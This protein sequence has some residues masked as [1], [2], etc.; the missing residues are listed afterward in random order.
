MRDLKE[1]NHALQREVTV[2]RDSIAKTHEVTNDLK[3]DVDL[4][5]SE[6]SKLMSTLRK[7]EKERDGLHV[8]KQELQGKFSV[9]E[10][11]LLQV[12]TLAVCPGAHGCIDLIFDYSTY[13]AVRCCN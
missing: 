7:T 13:T 11:K 10:N 6:N 8:E 1:D 5:S 12:G 4:L 3:K 2:Q 9:C